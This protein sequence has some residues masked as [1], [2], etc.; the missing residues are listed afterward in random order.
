MKVLE[1]KERIVGIS[2]LNEDLIN[3]YPLTD[4]TNLNSAWIDYFSTLQS[5]LKLA[6]LWRQSS[7]S[8]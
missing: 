4:F 5:K 8:A 1:R 2:D 6:A 3:L 7:K